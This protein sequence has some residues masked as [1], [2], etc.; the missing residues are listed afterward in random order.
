VN[1]DEALQYVLA[2]LDELLAADLTIS[3]HFLALLGESDGLN[4]PFGPLMK[5]L[6]R[7]SHFVLEKAA[8]LLA[9][10]LTAPSAMA[11]HAEQVLTRHL[12]TFSEWV[13]FQLKS[14]EPK[15]AADSPKTQFAVGALQ[16]LVATPSGRAVCIN[17][18]GLPILYGLISGAGG[19]SSVQ[20]LYQTIFSLW[21]LSYSPE[22]ALAMVTSKV[23]IIAKLVEVL[24]SVQKEKVIRVTLSTLRNLL[25]TATASADMVAAGVMPILSGLQPRKWAD[26]DILEDVDLLINALQVNLQTL[27]SWDVYKK[28]LMSGKLDWTPSHKSE[29][30]WKDNYK[31]FEA[32][33]F[34]ALKQLVALL[35]SEDAQ[36]LAIACNDTAEYIKHSPDGRRLMTQHG[37]KHPAMQALKYPDPAVQKYALACVQRLM[38]INWEYLSKA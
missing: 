30:F 2:L 11:G 29:S 14:V 24:K 18:D 28:E 19:A 32:N 25:G 36:V 15:D 27:T 12:Q 37:A 3:K 38:V 9:K 31:A 16:S 23:G 10:L 22:A 5:L 21:S 8:A 33:G 34:E 35:S 4:D 13:M 7:S 20:L 6:T 26:E 1:K 17:S